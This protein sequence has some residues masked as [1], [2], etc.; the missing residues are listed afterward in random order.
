MNDCD[1]CE[2]TECEFYG[3]NFVADEPTGR[4]YC[5]DCGEE[6]ENED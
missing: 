6:Q 5:E 4:I 1:F 2:W 3:H